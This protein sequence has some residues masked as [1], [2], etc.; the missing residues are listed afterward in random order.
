MSTAT[1]IKSFSYTSRNASGKVVKGKIEAPS[2]AAA[3]SRIRGLGL[4]PLAVTEASTG[5]LNTEIKIPGFEKGV[6]LKDLAIMSRQMATM[7]G[8]GLSLLKALS[9][10]SSQTDN[11]KLGNILHQV[12]L[13]VESGG[14]LSDAFAKHPVDF[15]P[16][17]INMIAAGE[18]GGF[19]EG[20]LE[21]LAVSYEKE[22]KMRSQIKSAMAYPVMVLVM[23]FVAVI[24]MLTFIVPVFKKMFEGLG[25]QLPGPTQ[26]LV[27]LSE[28]MV[29]IIPVLAV[30]LIGGSV[31]WRANRNTDAVRKVVDPLKLR[32]PIFGKLV[33]KIA[34]TRFCRNFA[35]MVGG[36]VPILTSLSVVG[37]TSGNYV[38]T[39]AT[40]RIAESVRQGQSI[41]K[42][43]ADE[44][45][46]PAMVVQM[47]AVGE[48]SGSLDT[49]LVKIADFYDAEV[50][51]MTD[52]LTSLIEPLLIAFLGVV[53]GG[54][55]VALYLPIFN[56]ATAVK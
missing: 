46:F 19:L 56:I 8:A 10:L 15:P 38:I 31:W 12:S 30:V 32:M 25:S 54:M 18:T 9:I 4:A 52:A 45:V 51:A 3:L 33:Q 5:G 26:L 1:A 34:I 48:D 21:S 41:A 11:K 42:P 22:S 40:E 36:G 23:S 2:E 50:E 17:M 44:K 35:N 39:H 16:L 47:M 53:V 55:V 20:A 6:G 28:N 13:D 14:A 7:I 37:Q 29:W 27:T 24:L 49:M 43:L